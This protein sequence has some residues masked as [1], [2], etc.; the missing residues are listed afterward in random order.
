MPADKVLESED[1]TT[2]AKWVVSSNWFSR[3]GCYCHY[4][5]PALKEEAPCWSSAVDTSNVS[6][7]GAA[8][9]F[10]SDTPSTQER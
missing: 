1:R 6:W 2:H 10:Q 8:F 3:Q 9:G 5:L 7:G 4:Y